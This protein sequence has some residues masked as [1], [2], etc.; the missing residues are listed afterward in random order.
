[1]GYLFILLCM[2]II[3][4]VIYLAI[5]TSAKNSTKQIVETFKASESEPYNNVEDITSPQYITDK[6][7]RHY[8]TSTTLIKHGGGAILHKFLELLPNS[9]VFMGFS[10]YIIEDKYKPEKGKLDIDGQQIDFEYRGRIIIEGKSDDLKPVWLQA[11]WTA[12]HIDK[13]E[14]AEEWAETINEDRYIK[15]IDSIYLVFGKHLRVQIKYETLRQ[16]ML[17]A[18]MKMKLRLP[19]HRATL[20]NVIKYRGDWNVN[21]SSATMQPAIP[22]GAINI[23]YNPAEF[24]LGDRKFSVPMSD[25]LN[26]CQM[27]LLRKNPVSAAFYGYHGTGKSYLIEQLA[28]MVA[29]N[30]RVRVIQGSKELLSCI[31][32]PEFNAFK[33]KVFN[34]YFYNIILIDEAEE[35]FLDPHI[36]STLK[37]LLSG[38]LQK[39]LNA[40]AIIAF[41]G[42]PQDYDEAL[43]RAGRCIA[44]DV[45]PI[46]V[47]TDRERVTAASEIITG[48]TKQPFNASHFEAYRKENKKDNKGNVICP[49][50]YIT[51]GDLFNCHQEDF[52]ALTKDLM[53]NLAKSAEKYEVG[54]KVNLEIIHTKKKNKK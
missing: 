16:L 34:P 43:F 48:I 41:N 10:P 22:D 52:E 44:V 31:N 1:M 37:N 4:A 53:G 36:K 14:E 21:P 50:G 6:F 25:Y 9:E 42:E 13:V 2:S 15:R 39:S 11:N 45:T 29:Q 35:L 5:H 51:L 3:G 40:S 33:E 7:T 8:A 27:W 12:I 24:K 49:S 38:S 26:L 18:K 28:Y 46:K 23:F 47:D 54:K 20:H 32:T 17:Q 30:E 19:E